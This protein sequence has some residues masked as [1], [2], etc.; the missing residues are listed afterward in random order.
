MEEDERLG[1]ME[2]M[3]EEQE[4][5]LEI[6]A[7]FDQGSKGL[8]KTLQEDDLFALEVATQLHI[9]YSNVAKL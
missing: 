6:K 7:R 2:R 3:Q 5:L 9:A 8:V 1:I 4:A